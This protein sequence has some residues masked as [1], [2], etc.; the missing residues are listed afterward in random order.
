MKSDKYYIF[1]YQHNKIT[2]TLCNCFNQVII[3]MGVN[4]DNNKLAI[5]A[6]PKII[7]LDLPKDVGNNLKHEIIKHNEFLAEHTIRN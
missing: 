2:A 7:H 5:I 3:V 4:I 1:L 6:E